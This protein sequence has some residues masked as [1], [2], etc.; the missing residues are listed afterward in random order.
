MAAG[1]L[2]LLRAL[3]P[4]QMLPS[5]RLEIVVRAPA[6][7]ERRQRNRL[8][9]PAALA[10]LSQADGCRVAHLRGVARSRGA[11]NFDM[12]VLLQDILRRLHDQLQNLVRFLLEALELLLHVVLVHQ[13]LPRLTLEE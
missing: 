9:L 6:I 2:G 4:P 8:P 10:R 11:W 1:F 7:R 12:Q 5:R 13:M 3:V